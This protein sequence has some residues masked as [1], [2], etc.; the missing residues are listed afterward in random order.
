MAATTATNTAPS[1]AVLEPSTAVVFTSS[2]VSGGFAGGLGTVLFQ[3]LDTLKVRMQTST[4][5]ARGAPTSSVALFSH[6]VRTEGVF[7]LWRG[8]G[9]PIIAAALNSSLCFSVTSTVRQVLHGDEARP[10]SDWRNVAAC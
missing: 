4:Q 10:I 2:F 6:M 5:G 7:S 1:L 8:G 9:P 3:P